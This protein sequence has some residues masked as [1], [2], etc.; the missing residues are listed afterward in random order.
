MVNANGA[1]W[2]IFLWLL[3]LTAEVGGSSP[4]LL[5]IQSPDGDIV[6]CVLR[7]NQPAFQHPLLKNHKLQEPPTHVPNMFVNEAQMGYNLQVWHQSGRRCPEGSI[8]IRRVASKHNGTSSSSVISERTKSHEYVIGAMENKPKIYGTEVTMNV[9]H[10]VIEGFN[11]FSL[12][13]IWL[14]SGSYDDRDLNSIEAGWQTDAYN[15]TGG[16]NLRTGG[17]VQTSKEIMVEG[18][19]S[20]TSILGGDQVDLT[21][22][23]WKDTKS[24]SWWLGIIIGRNVLEPVGYWPASLFTI[25]TD[26][27]AIVQWGGEITNKNEYGRHTKTQMGSGYF[28]DSGRGKVAYM[29]NLKIALTESEFQPLQNLTVGATHPEYYRGEKLNDT[30]FYYGGPQQLNSKAAHPM[31]DYTI[32]LVNFSLA[33]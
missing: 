13:Q 1:E 5:T 17:F 30:C 19:I 12:G 20:Q 32:L 24:K 11:E 14:T 9:W 10:P 33:Y 25:Q 7:E 26:Y 2:V 4:P 23:I 28:P 18:A 16:Y 21:I 8:P 31:L 27:A 29:R 6:D 22:R 15:L 3:L